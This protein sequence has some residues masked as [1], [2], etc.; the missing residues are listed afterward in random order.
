MAVSYLLWVLRV[1]LRPSERPTSAFNHSAPPGP[2]STSSLTAMPLVHLPHDSTACKFTALTMEKGGEGRS[3]H[4]TLGKEVR[5]T[6]EGNSGAGAIL[7]H[8]LTFLHL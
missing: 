6:L 5:L 3:E 8:L 1:E 2:L 4:V 7:R